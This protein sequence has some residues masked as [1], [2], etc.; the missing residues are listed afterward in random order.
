M[1]GLPSEEA[2]AALAAQ[3]QQQTQ[4]PPPTQALSAAA[5][6]IIEL[7]WL[8]DRGLKGLKLRC[9]VTTPCP[10]G[11]DPVRPGPD[12]QSLQ[13]PNRADPLCILK[14]LSRPQLDLMSGTNVSEVA[15]IERNQVA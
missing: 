11:E 2:G 15:L 9:R 6:G 13:R 7:R 14:W 1:R 8:A 5:D 10:H 4:G 3:E 12:N